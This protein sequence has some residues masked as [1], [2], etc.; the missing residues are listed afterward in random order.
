MAWDS[1]RSARSLRLP[2]DWQVR[3]LRV[4]RRDG[5]RCQAH[6]EDSPG[7]CGAPARDVDHIDRGDNHDLTNL[8]ALCPWH[9]NRKS[10]REGAAARKAKPTQKR[11][12]EAHPGALL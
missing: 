6:L 3:R 5:Y 10:S 4:L 7:L 12:P 8:Q 1:G 2:D 9:H 11:A